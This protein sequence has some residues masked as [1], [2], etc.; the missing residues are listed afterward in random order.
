M[1]LPFLH[2]PFLYI[3]VF[4]VIALLLAKVAKRKFAKYLNPPRL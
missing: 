3:V 4:A 2:G 1:N